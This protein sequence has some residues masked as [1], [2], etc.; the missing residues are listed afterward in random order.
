MVAQISSDVAEKRLANERL[1]VAGDIVTVP[2][3]SVVFAPQSA[4]SP[5]KTKPKLSIALLVARIETKFNLEAELGT[6]FLFWPVWFGCGALLYFSLSSEPELQPI[7]AT[8][9]VV[10]CLNLLVRHVAFPRFILTAL[11]LGCLGFAAAKI[12][13]L[14]FS[15][16]MMGSEVTTRI[17]GTLVHAEEI[18][19]G[20]T[21][22]VIE[23]ISTERPKLKFAPE[24]VRVSV[25][26]SYAQQPAG[27]VVSGLVKLFALPGPVQP[28]GYDFAFESYFDSVGAAGFFLGAPQFVPSTLQ[29]TLAEKIDGARTELTAHIRSIVPGETGAVVAAL[30]TGIRGAVVEADN[31]ALRRSGLAHIMSISGL[32]LALAAGVLIAAIRFGF[33]IFPAISDVFPVKKIAASAGIIMAILYCMLSGSEVATLRS[34]IMI[35][36]MLG[37]VLVDRPAIT[38]RNLAIAALVLLAIWPHEIAGPGFQM[39]FAATAGLIAIYRWWASRPYENNDQSPKLAW[40]ILGIAKTAI[41]GTILSSTVAGLA[42]LPFGAFHFERLA[43][44][45]TL[46]NLLALPAISL[47]VMPS[48]VAAM[49]AFPFGLD[50]Y[51]WPIMALG[52]EF[53]LWLAHTISGFG[54]PDATG[55]VPVLALLFSTLSLVTVCLLQ[56]RLKVLALIPL[57]LAAFFFIARDKPAAFVSEDA[58]LVAY[59]T[60]N[61]QLAVSASRVDEFSVKNWLR[62]VQADSTIKPT[63]VGEVT[64]ATQPTEGFTCSKLICL[65]ELPNGLKIA[66][67]KTAESADL[68][69]EI[70]DLVVQGYAGAP[71]GCS[72]GAKSITSSMLARNG[73]AALYVQ[74]GLMPESRTAPNKRNQPLALVSAD[75]QAYQIEWSYQT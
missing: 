2:E 39:S 7:L 19:N 15:T 23:I 24:R 42:T 45:G 51:I 48:A 22:L 44:W 41:I 11:L 70:A 34:T 27:S 65:G 72:S 73:T 28:H 33:A 49:L 32:H 74:S 52:V 46:S 61:G 75:G 71:I 3:V 10:F 25:R 6:A 60:N 57:A 54:G 66:Q 63:N 47:V 21:R 55:P 36:V 67:T 68:A 20:R 50:A 69:C 1:A 31:E 29:Q 26:G 30:V 59:V 9:G 18:S 5:E 35:V 13:M 37:A 14:R 4:A 58:K 8:T 62:T 16:V 12:E 38:I 56:T 43:P 40:R 17:T 53:M 64:Y